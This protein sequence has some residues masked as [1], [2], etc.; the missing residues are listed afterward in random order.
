M[1]HKIAFEILSLG[2]G[3]ATVGTVQYVFVFHIDLQ[4]LTSAVVM[5]YVSTGACL[6]Y[7]LLSTDWK[8]VAL[9]IQ[10]QNTDNASGKMASDDEHANETLY[11]A[12]RYN[13]RAAR[14]SARRNIRLLTLPPGQRSG[15][16][17]GSLFGRPGASVLLVRDWSPMKGSVRPGDS[18]LAVDGVDVSK[19]GATEVSDRLKTAKWFD[20][21]VTIT[22]PPAKSK[23]LLTF[24][25][26]LRTRA[27]L[28]PQRQ[29]ERHRP[30]QMTFAP[31]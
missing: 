19:E 26:W 7:L 9:K 22:A 23:N 30:I 16:L 14:E 10:E 6:T 1:C 17:L 27:L 29:L 24:R 13:S 28:L 3:H 15:M 4:G 2:L 31:R 8:K 21:H 12:L 5:G 11:A 20:R 25:N 18:I